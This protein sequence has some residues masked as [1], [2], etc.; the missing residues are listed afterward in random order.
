MSHRLSV[1]VPNY[2]GA[3]VLP[4]CLAALA[5]QTVAPASVVVIDN[6]STDGSDAA[7]E[8]D[9]PQVQVRRMGRNL[10]F[11]AAANL[12]VE[13]VSTELVAVLNSDA[14]PV[15][16]WVEAVTGF[17]DTAPESAW[18]WGG[19]LLAPDG[20]LESAGDCYS[21]AGFAYKHAQGELVERIPAEPYEVFAPPGAA[22]VFRREVFQQ[23]GGYDA[24]YFLYL[25][26]IDLAF[27]GRARGYTC[28]LVPQAAVEH[29]LGGSGSANVA[30]WHIARNAIWCWVSNVPELHPRLLWRTTRRE[31]RDARAKGVGA[32]FVRGR[33]VGLLALPRLLAHR[34][35]ERRQ[36]VVP[37]A[38]LLRAVALPGQLD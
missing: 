34:R 5:A 22:P 30:T 1:V 2:N 13:G 15:P 9:F 24:R 12:G 23:L 32:V 36:R 18:S 20:L 25:E 8:R 31:H 29:D 35:A 4:R 38:E 14:R 26:D 21:V 28:W 19:P 6:G 37:S 10:G 33:L 17:A 27:R 7:V 11:G 3:H 16:G